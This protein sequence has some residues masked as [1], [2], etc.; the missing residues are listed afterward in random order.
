MNRLLNGRLLKEFNVLCS[1]I[2]RIT[3]RDAFRALCI[4]CQL[5]LGLS[6]ALYV[7]E[8]APGLHLVSDIGV[9]HKVE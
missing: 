5:A 7:Y 4:I 6:M 1:L 8:L 3:R 9:L 2:G